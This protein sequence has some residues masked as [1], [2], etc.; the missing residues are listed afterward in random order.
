MEDLRSHERDRGFLVRAIDRPSQFLFHAFYSTREDATLP[1]L[2]VPYYFVGFWDMVMSKETLYNASMEMTCKTM[3][4]VCL[5]W[6]FL[7]F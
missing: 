3:L 6:M 4:K 2:V 1:S 5:R 7:H